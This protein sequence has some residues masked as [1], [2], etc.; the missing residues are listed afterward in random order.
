MKIL[1]KLEIF[2]QWQGKPPRETNNFAIRTLDGIESP[3][4]VKEMLSYGPTH[5]AKDKFNEILFPAEVDKLV[6]LL[7]GNGT[8]G[9]K[10][11]KIES[12]IKCYAKNVKEA[13]IESCIVKVNKHFKKNNYLAV[14]FDKKNGYCSMKR[15]FSERKLLDVLNCLQFKE[16][17]SENDS[18]NVN[19]EKN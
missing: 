14:P 7:R 9:E 11:C 8:S 15:E 16:M 4:F 1:S 19:I 6:R 10:P 18:I 12:A 3:V 17:E 2:L 5:P 13:S